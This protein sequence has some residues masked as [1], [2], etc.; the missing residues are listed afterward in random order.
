MYQSIQLNIIPFTPIENEVKI[1]LYKEYKEGFCPLYVTE[2]LNGLLD[3]YMT[4]L[5]QADT[6]WL[7]TDFQEPKEG[8]IVVNIHLAIH[9]NFANHYYRHSISNYFKNGVAHIMHRNFIKE[10]EVWLLNTETENPKYNLYNQFTLKVQHNK[11]T[12]GAE[13]VISFDGKTK[14]YKQS[15]AQ[16]VGFPTEQLNWINCNGILHKYDKRPDEAKLNLDKSFPVISNFLKPQLGIRFDVP[17]LSNRY[18]KYFEAL[19][20]F[21]NTYLNTPKFH[22]VLNLAS[23]GFL[24]LPQDAIKILSGESQLL[25]F[26]KG[27]GVEPKLDLKKLGPFRPADNAHNVKFF[28]ISHSS[29]VALIETIKDHFING[30]KSHPNLQAFIHQPFSFDDSLNIEFNTLVPNKIIA[31][32]WS[33]LK[34][35]AKQSNLKYFA[36]YISPF[37]KLYVKGQEKR[38]YYRIKEMLLTEEY[39]SQAL[40]KENITKPAFNFFLPNIQI[41]I[42]AKIGGKPWI[43]KR[44]PSDELIIGIGAFYNISKKTRY[45]GS[46]FCFNNMGEFKN[47]TCFR[48]D[49]IYALAGSIREAVEEF[50][51]SNKQA[52]R[53]IIHFYKIISKRELKPI[54]DTLYHK[55]KLDIPVIIVTINKTASKDLLAFDTNSI[56][57]LM[58]ISG[59]YINVAEREYLLFNNTRYNQA[60]EPAQKEYHFPVKLKLTSTNLVLLEDT[61]LVEKLIDQ[62]YQFSR[63]YW[64]SVSQQNLPV[65]IAYSEMIAEVYSY[66]KY[67]AMPDFAKDKLW[68]L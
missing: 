46:A 35:R 11:V 15:L 42:L 39:L 60:S 20:N 33:V 52:K 23:T 43:L 3:S 41:A 44:D 51:K 34:D 22:K 54:L 24:N 2:D 14:V 64:K 19:N 49:D 53:L 57:K 21:Y 31:S 5:E 58:P 55:L 56:D 40:F 61:E 36:I 8:A 13:L 68:F 30:F 1:A 47:F 9:T 6:V 27:N 7:Y 28:F 65:T 26:G 63:M 10:I 12:N 18:P 48:D 25:Q 62:V 66:F 59:T 32:I 37:N 50:R 45:L 4:K 67:D 29:D 38:V 17:D 16:M